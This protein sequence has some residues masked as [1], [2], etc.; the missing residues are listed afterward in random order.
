M[1]SAADIFYLVLA[2]LFA[3]IMFQAAFGLLPRSR[4]RAWPFRVTGLR[5]VTLSRFSIISVIVGSFGVA[6]AFASAAFSVQSMG[7]V[8]LMFSIV[9]FIL[10]SVSRSRDVRNFRQQR[11]AELTR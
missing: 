6:V 3:V 7:F 8:G 9:G 4:P 10:V 5:N 1:H 11:L 2:I